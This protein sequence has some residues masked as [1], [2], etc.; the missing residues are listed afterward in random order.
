[1]YTNDIPCQSEYNNDGNF[2]NMDND[3]DS[4]SYDKDADSNDSNDEEYIKVE[5][6]KIMTYLSLLVVGI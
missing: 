4:Y 6:N 1:M 3:Y 5:T 2:D